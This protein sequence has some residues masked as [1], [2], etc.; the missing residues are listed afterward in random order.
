M[1]TELGESGVTVNAIAPGLTRTET[2]AGGPLVHVFDAVVAQQ[3]I[4]RLEE[5]E[6]LAGTLAFLTSD[7]AA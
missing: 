5:P 7:D 2:T 4:K 6:D 1:A 3:A